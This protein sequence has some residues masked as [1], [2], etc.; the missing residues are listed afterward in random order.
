MREWSAEQTLQEQVVCPLPTINDWPGSVPALLGHAVP[1]DAAGPG[2][3]EPFSMQGW[4]W[5]C[6]ETPASGLDARPSRHAVSVTRVLLISATMRAVPGDVV[7][8]LMFLI[9]QL[10]RWGTGKMSSWLVKRSELTRNACRR[11]W[12]HLHPQR[13]QSTQQICVLGEN[14][15]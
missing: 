14:I 2:T 1:C 7:T 12:H 13:G 8:G 5:M 10:W 11:D 15:S 9:N 6:G 4:C 3:A